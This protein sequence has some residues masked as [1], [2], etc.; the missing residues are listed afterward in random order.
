[1][2][3]TTTTAL[4]PRAAFARAVKSPR[5]AVS[6]G[7]GGVLWWD[8]GRQLS[9]SRRNSGGEGGL[10]RVT[11]NGT[12]ALS[13]T[14]GHR[15]R[16]ASQAVNACGKGFGGVAAKAAMMATTAAAPSLCRSSRRCGP[17]T[18][19]RG[20]WSKEN[21]SVEES[22]AGNV[23]PPSTR[24][25]HN[26][27]NSL[28][29]YDAVEVSSSPAAA[30]AAAVTSAPLPVSNAS[31]WWRALKLPMYSVAIAPLT[32]AASLCHHWYGCINVPQC[33]ALAA[34]ACLIIAWLNL[35]NDAWDAATGV[36]ANGSGGKAESVVRLL[37]GGAAAVSKVHVAAVT[38]LVFGAAALLKAAVTT[39]AAA[40][41]TNLAGSV[42]AM[43]AAAIA[44]GHAYQGPPFRLSYKGLGEPI[45][46]TAF[47]PLAVGAFYLA[48]AAGTG[49]SVWAG[50]HRQH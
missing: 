23:E 26:A 11:P 5:R 20:F 7:S 29:G 1:M 37:G 4:Q 45:C 35:S 15:R 6:C 19:M 50:P 30:E 46:F 9:A 31:L 43:L 44:L 47:G 33:G 18:V 25:E 2:M 40:T 32:V 39:A 42:G 22:T 14:D 49:G 38:C 24:V 36:D 16:R 41:G 28:G 8:S 34:G 21:V 10:A 27:L 48:L 3:T 17:R 12:G 13:R